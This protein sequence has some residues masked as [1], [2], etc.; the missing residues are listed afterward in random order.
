MYGEGATYDSIE[1]RFRIIRKEADKLKS[2]IDSG[3]RDPAPPRGTA[4]SRSPRKRRQ[5]SVIDLDS[6]ETGRISKP[7]ST[8]NSPSKRRSA[9]QIKKEML[10]TSTSTSSAGDANASAS[11][12]NVGQSDDPDETYVPANMEFDPSVFE[13]FHASNFNA[14]SFNASMTTDPTDLSFLDEF[15]EPQQYV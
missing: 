11:A 13:S 6:V 4:S 10:E 2:E 5:A 8:Q 1:G 14:S 9:A 7:S 15:G 12:S 3:T